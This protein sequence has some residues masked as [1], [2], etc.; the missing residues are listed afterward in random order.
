MTLP[1]LVL[2]HSPL[3][4]PLTWQGVAAHLAEAGALVVTP[5]L[6]TAV[7]SEPPHHQGIAHTVASSLA[8][9]DRDTPIALVGHSG[10]GPLLPRIATT[11]SH[12]VSALIYVDSVLPRPGESWVANAP[13]S[14]VDHLRDLVRNGRLPPWHEWFPP[15]VIAEILPD[16]RLRAAFIRELPRLPFTYFTEQTSID[17]WPGPAG[18]LLL[19]DGYQQDAQAARQAGMPVV[20]QIEHHLAMLTEPAAVSAALVRLIAA[21]DPTDP[22]IDNARNR[23]RPETNVRDTPQSPERFPRTAL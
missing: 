11:V 20:E 22:R 16:S 10:A 1:A 18:Y 5:D 8:T 14:L 2:L 6:T 12:Q 19:S 23:Q 17:D 9:V 7:A 4:G 13:Q 21:T 3:V 15:E